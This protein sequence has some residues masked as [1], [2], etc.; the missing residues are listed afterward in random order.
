MFNVN[1][2]GTNVAIKFYG[3]NEIQVYNYKIIFRDLLQLFKIRTVIR[4]LLFVLFSLINTKN[5]KIS[6]L[7][8]EWAKFYS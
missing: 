1:K 3:S 7:Q 6:F 2:Y 5:I 4:I 8:K